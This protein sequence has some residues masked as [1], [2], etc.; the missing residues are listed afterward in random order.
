MARAVGDVVEAMGESNYAKR[1]QAIV[2]GPAWQEQAGGPTVLPELLDRAANHAAGRQL[3]CLGP[4]GEVSCQLSYADFRAAAE[5]L[6]M[7]LGERGLRAG[8]RVLLQL[9]RHCDFLTALWGCFL[10]GVLPLPIPAPASYREPSSHLNALRYGLELT[11]PS[12]ILTDA[13]R[14][15]ALE[16]TNPCLSDHPVPAVA[17]EDLRG[18]S[19][20]GHRPSMVPD[21]PALLILTSGTTARPKAVVLTHRNLVST[22]MASVQVLRLG[23]HDTNVNWMPLEH[24]GA[25]AFHIRDIASGARQV[26]VP[27][28]YV[29][30]QPQ[31]WLDLLDRYGA[32]V[33]WAP[34][35]AFGL[36]N[37]LAELPQPG[38]WNLAA[39]RVLLN[40]SE[41]IVPRT[42]DRFLELLGPLGL[43]ADC[44]TPCW[45]MSETSAAVTFGRF[46]RSKFSAESTGVE[47]TYVATGKPLPGVSLRIV[48]DRDELVPEGRVGRLQVKGCAV[49][50]GYYGDEQSTR[51]SLTADGWWQTGDLGYLRGGELTVTGREA[52]R[53]IIHGVNYSSQAIEVTAGAVAGVDAA[54]VAACAVR[55][56]GDDTDRLA[57]FFSP[58]QDGP[59]SVE[60]LAARIRR[61]VIQQIGA[62]VTYT[63]AVQPNEMPRTATG[64][65]KH[66]ELRQRLERG[67]FGQRSPARELPHATDHGAEIERCVAAA[68][69]SVLG[70][71]R[72]GLDEDFFDADGDSLR[73][74]QVLS[75]I[76]EALNVEL[77]V[78]QLFVAPTVR[79]LAQCVRA[80][81]K[82]VVVVDSLPVPPHRPLEIPLST[83]QQRLW[84]SAQLDPTSP[85]YHV[86]VAVDYGD[87]SVGAFD[88]LGLV[89][90]VALERSLEM[91]VH[92]HEMLRVAIPALDGHPRQVIRPI[93]PV[94]LA[95]RDL[96]G[97]DSA[98]RD[99]AIHREGVW[100]Q[101]PFDLAQG[102]LWRAC[103]LQLEEERFLFF[104]TL[105]HII[106]DG[107]SVGILRRELAACYAAYRAGRDPALAPL[108]LRDAAYAAW[109]RKPS[110]GDE[111]QQLGYWRRRLEG[112]TPMRLPGD[113]SRLG[114][115]SHRGRLR[116]ITL[117][118]P[119]ATALQDLGRREGAT[120]FMVLL[121]AFQV[122]WKRFLGQTDIAVGS[123]IAQRSRRELEGV[124]GFFVNTLVLRAHVDGQLS[125]RDFLS[126][127]REG[128]LEAYAHQDFPFERLLEELQPARRPD[129]SSLF[130]VMFAVHNL[131]LQPLVLD[132]VAVRS[133]KCDTNAVR[134]DLQWDIWKQDDGLRVNA[135]YGSELFEET[136]VDRW[137]ACYRTLIEGIVAD[138]D[139]RLD[140]LPLIGKEERWCVLG[141]FSRLST[142]SP[143]A[144]C[145][146]EVFERQVQRTPNAVAVVDRDV[147]WNY[148]QLNERANAIAAMLRAADVRPDTVVAVACERSAEA[149]AALLGVLKAGGAYLPLDIGQPAERWKELWRESGA[150]VLLAARQLAEPLQCFSPRSSTGIGEGPVAVWLDDASQPWPSRQAAAN[151]TS[152]TAA[153]HL[154]C[155]MC[156]SGT[157][158]R[159]KAVGVLHRG[160]VRLVRD[161]GYIHVLPTDVFL[162]LAPPAFDASTFEIWAP[163]LNGARLV[164][165]PSG[166]WSPHELARL[167]RHHGVSVLWLTA[168]LF[169]LM[170]EQEPA[171]LRQLRVLLAGGDVLPPEQVRDFFAGPR[172]SELVN[173]YGPTENTTF[174]CCHRMTSPVEPGCS[175]PIGRPISQTHVY[176]L[177]EGLQPAP[178]GAV[179]ELYVGG[180]GLTRG[181]LNQPG[182]TAERF[183]PDPFHGRAGARLYRTGDLVR[184]RSDGVLEFLGRKDRQLKIRGIRIEPGPIEAA[185]AGHPA[186]REA[187]VLARETSDG[188]RRLVGYILTDHADS[189]AE[190]RQFLRGRFPASHIPQYLVPVPALPLTPHGK[191]DYRALAELPLDKAPDRVPFVRPR[192][193]TEEKL[194]AIWSAVLA[195]PRIGIHDN[196][197]D[198]GGES[199][200]AMKVIA[201]VWDEL[202]V[203]VPLSRLFAGPTIAELAVNVAQQFACASDER[204]LAE[205]LDE[206]ERM[207]DEGGTAVKEA[208]SDG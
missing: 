129:G 99:A 40:G 203:V 198:L 46:Q 160:I 114:V 94:R 153:D 124:V 101:Q 208:P 59:D 42:V 123:P 167:L 178:I 133:W 141:E 104:W 164:L 88:L 127:V 107:W 145:V 117:P 169:R 200:L 84:L 80:A 149:I 13:V 77:P 97:L 137:L 4:E 185:L 166:V 162:Q 112:L 119:L 51:Q 144:D 188:D 29:L 20:H 10:S 190:V 120:L 205:T 54:H 204:V 195:V 79:Q 199:L 34:N 38:R 181:Y 172:M 35:S 49:T 41:A 171:A 163:L 67:G 187:V 100:Q 111:L 61:Q 2:H 108:P 23:P 71:D 122:L 189:V 74:S 154:A 115:P 26:H 47:Q 70:R 103:L 176:V 168:A 7:A 5:D 44:M 76:R 31:R 3:I 89:D 128:A 132:D 33:C 14:V 121:A 19:V 96:R 27:T 158:G 55:L 105:H 179:G 151:P 86:S 143:E 1:G 53:I 43:P 63:I 57:I 191:V 39:L 87:P 90:A 15:S 98:A 102:P 174:T 18:T 130:Q 157:T 106:C 138:P 36:V 175:V 68:F 64:K 165:P 196:F 91:I 30:A 173:G 135:F 69:C 139:G 118:E 177:Q 93:Q 73:G 65:L 58:R 56:E 109:Q 146:H 17:I 125:F 148:S 182:A 183:V 75:R 62:P 16:E 140:D 82:Q 6:A 202:H 126:R 161:A 159:P 152:G 192:T 194:A 37:E 201:R 78:R 60:E 95:F 186:V 150:Q 9:P 32:T 21:D 147:Q 81:L 206:V 156:T 197:F 72:I 50:P 22:A 85:A 142:E 28:D 155:V 45:G 207:E 66:V 180:A 193:V 12:F 48:D 8:D 170:V 134:F 116:S 24:I 92:R 136:T 131:P 11:R 184:F 83:A 52:S 25:L 110:E 113:H